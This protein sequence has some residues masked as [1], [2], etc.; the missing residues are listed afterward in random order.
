MVTR[1][2]ASTKTFT[3]RNACLFSS[4]Q[5]TSLFSKLCILGGGQMA[6]AILGSL[7]IKNTQK[8]SDIF[9]YDVNAE[10]LEFLRSKYGI[11][12]CNNAQLAVDNSEVTILAVKPQSV[13]TLAESI[14]QAPSGLLLSIVAGLTIKEL[15]QKFGTNKIIRSMPNTPAMVHE[16][17]T[18]WTSTSDTPPELKEKAKVLFD[19]FGEQVEVHDE[20]YLPMATAIS[21]SGPAVSILFIYFD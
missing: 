20:I 1:L 4:I 8:M 11:T 14:N 17:I 7:Q 19:L 2:F 10:R 16:G 13:S 5:E 15:K 12:I 9:V 6:S 3:T 21:R 18:V